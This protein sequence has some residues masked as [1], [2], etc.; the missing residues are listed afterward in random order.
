MHLTHA[1]NSLPSHV[2]VRFEDGAHSFLLRKGATLSELA[3][4]IGVLRARHADKLISIDV[5]CNRLR[6]NPNHRRIKR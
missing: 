1:I 5:E 6:A 3:K 4:C 2:T